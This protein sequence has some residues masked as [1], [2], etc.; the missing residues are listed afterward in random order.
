MKR[1]GLILI[2]FAAGCGEYNFTPIPKCAQGQALTG[3]GN[4][5][6]CVDVGGPA[7]NGGGADMKGAGGGDMAMPAFPAVP[8]CGQGR[9]LTG[10][11][12]G[13]LSCIDVAATNQTIVQLQNDLTSLINRVTA[14]EKIINGGGAGGAGKFVGVT[15]ATS[16]GRI[17]HQGVDVGL[18]SAA[19]YCADEFGAGAHMCTNNELYLSV[20]TGKLTSKDTITPSAWVYFPTWQNPLGAAQQPRAG[21]GDNCASYTYPTNDRLWSGNAVEWKTNHQGDAYA[22]WWHG[23]SEA[24]CNIAR[25]IACCK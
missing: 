11:N 22:F 25:P 6:K 24:T 16:K 14:L 8:A 23:G 9:C 4:A 3:D 12:A 1:V 21:M 10:D 2:A 17:D 15:K 5:L 13:Q 19:A 20:A 18:A 7:G